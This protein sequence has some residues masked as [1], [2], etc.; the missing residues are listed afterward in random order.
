MLQFILGAIG[1][2]ALSEISKKGKMPIM[3]HGGKIDYEK[4]KKADEIYREHNRER[5]KKGIEEFSQ[6]SVDLWNEKYDDRLNKLNLTYDEK[7]KL[8][9]KNWYAKGGG[10]GVNNESVLRQNDRIF[11]TFNR[12][13][14]TIKD[15]NIIKIYDFADDQDD[16]DDKID[17]PL[18]MK[19]I[20]YAEITEESKYPENLRWMWFQDYFGKKQ[21]NKFR[22]NLEDILDDVY[23]L[24]AETDYSEHYVIIPKDE[25]NIDWEETFNY[26]NRT[27]SSIRKRKRERN[28]GTF[29]FARGY[30]DSENKFRYNKYKSDH[31]RM[32]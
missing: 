3:A 14:K 23:V 32:K 31:T 30:Y 19:N 10:V 17:L 16:E 28:E 4:V 15:S 7:V 1:V 12:P 20:S 6:E 11:F 24:K 2:V 8:N 27:A 29:K 5:I 22:L 9:P 13:L 21:D 26:I 18:P 25:I